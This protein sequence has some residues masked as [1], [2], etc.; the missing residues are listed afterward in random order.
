MELLLSACITRIS[1]VFS[2]QTWNTFFFFNIPVNYL[3]N[4][5]YSG[6]QAT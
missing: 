6:Q 1:A 2:N 4:S 3:N 5:V